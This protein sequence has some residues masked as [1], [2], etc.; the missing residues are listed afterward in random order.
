MPDKED[1]VLPTSTRKLTRRAFLKR[2]ALWS[3]A[4]LVPGSYGWATQ[5][6]PY[7]LEIRRVT[8][9]LPRLTPAFNN[10]TLAQIS[11]IHVG[12]WMSYE[13]LQ[14]VVAAINALKPDYVVIT[15]DFASRVAAPHMRVL[16]ALRAL[17]PRHDTL[18]V[19]GNHDHWSNA[20]EVRSTLSKIG[21]GEL[22]NTHHTLR[23]GKE[24]L[25][26]AGIDDAW[27]GAGDVN[28]VL[29][30]LPQEGAAILLAHEPDFADSHAAF[31]RFDA[32]LSGHS[33]GGQ[34][35]LPL[36]GPLVLPRYGQ[37]YHTGRY[38]VGSGANSMTLYVNRGIGMI[39]PYVRFNCRPEITFFT[40]HAPDV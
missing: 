36:I 23:R 9:R 29:D 33:H 6:E 28:A 26:I 3:G 8:L 5:I 13:R 17:S 10:L 34:I 4:A 14:R 35:Q 30:R 24:V 20:G 2:T 18:Y 25:H 31:G 32:Q 7:R 40:L 38:R 15:G 11:D 39:K 16:D 12:S 37:K 27:V 1:P 19:L 21:M 22:R